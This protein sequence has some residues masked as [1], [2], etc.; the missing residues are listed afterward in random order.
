[1]AWLEDLT[2]TQTMGAT[3]ANVLGLDEVDDDYFLVFEGL[4]QGHPLGAIKASFA[5]DFSPNYAQQH[6]DKIER[7]Y[8][9]IQDTQLFRSM[10]QSQTG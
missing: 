7:L 3:E 9:V 4:V 1:M 10:F 8:T 5:H 2:H 6:N